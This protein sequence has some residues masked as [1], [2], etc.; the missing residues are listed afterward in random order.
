MYIVRYSYRNGT[1][2]FQMCDCLGDI[3]NLLTPIK[4]KRGPN[5]CS[6]YKLLDEWHM[7]DPRYDCEE[8]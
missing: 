5:S 1:P 8:D 3:P 4:G 6:V 7:D 2:E